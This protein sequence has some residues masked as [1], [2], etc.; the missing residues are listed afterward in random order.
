MQSFLDWCHCA[1]EL[2]VL[3]VNLLHLAIAIGVSLVGY[4]VKRLT[5][6]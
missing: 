1:N 2:T 5:G 4:L 6:K 3:K